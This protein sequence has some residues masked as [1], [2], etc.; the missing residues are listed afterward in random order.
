M[1]DIE[2][3]NTFDQS[4]LNTVRRLK[5]RASYDKRQIADIFKQAKICHVAFLYDGLPQCIPMIAALEETP[6]GD[7]FV[8]FHGKHS[9][10]LY[11]FPPTLSLM[12]CQKGYSKA[13]FMEALMEKGTPMTATAT[14]FDGY[15]LALSVFNHSMNY[16]SAV[17]HGVSLPFDGDDDNG[18][19]RVLKLVVDSTTPGRWE[20]SR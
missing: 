8:Y 4:D 7:L 15:V 12:S 2:L 19:M 20:N 3:D 6:E 10:A 5:D 18:K 17:L 11:P 16:R 13:R 1:A 9:I 14:I